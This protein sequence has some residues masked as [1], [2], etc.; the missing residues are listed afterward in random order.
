MSEIHDNTS[1]LETKKKKG[2]TAKT[3]SVQNSTTKIQKNVEVF[4]KKNSNPNPII[5]IKSVYDEKGLVKRSYGM[6]MDEALKA[7]EVFLWGLNR[8]D[9]IILESYEKDYLKKCITKNIKCDENKKNNDESELHTQNLNIKTTDLIFEPTHTYN[10]CDIHFLKKEYDR[11]ENELSSG[12]GCGNEYNDLMELQD[13]LAE[14]IDRLEEERDELGLD[15]EPEQNSDEDKEDDKEEDNEDENENENDEDNDDNK[16]NKLEEGINVQKKR[17][18]AKKLKPYYLIGNIPEGYREAT[19][20]EAITN[21][22]VSWFGKRKVKRELY[23]LYCVCG[24]LFIPTS[25]LKEINL[26]KISLKGK[27][28]YY[29]K[30][31]DYCKVSLG[32]SKITPQH[33]LE[34]QEK[35]NEINDCHKKTLDVYK[36]YLDCIKTKKTNEVKIEISNEEINTPIEKTDIPNIK[37]NK[38]KK[39]IVENIKNVE[40]VEVVEVVD[41]VSKINNTKVIKIAK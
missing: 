28:N 34:I 1:C 6:S 8:V 19:Q 38:S 25:N 31:Y 4:K 3:N 41:D 26:K 9:S 35:M 10:P 22:K 39:I 2:R 33:A 7:N 16:Q 21:K 37:K 24:T 14:L 15:S 18:R 32:S 17:G 27:L 40:N 12:I 5:K 23:N 13:E 29:K 30:E 36:L 20:E 11:I